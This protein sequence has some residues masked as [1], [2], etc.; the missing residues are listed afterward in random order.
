MSKSPQSSQRNTAEDIGVGV[1]APRVFFTPARLRAYPKILLITYILSALLIIAIWGPDRLPFPRLGTDFVAMYGAGDLANQGRSSEAYD[2]RALVGNYRRILPEVDYVVGWAY[3]PVILP[4]F[5][6]L[7]IFPFSIAHLIWMGATAGLLATALRPLLKSGAEGWAIAAAPAVAYTVVTGQTA[8]LVAAL[9]LIF[10][11]QLDRHPARA[12]LALGA[13]CVKPHLAV[14]L[15]LLA[16]ATGK[17]RALGTA[18]LLTAALVVLSVVLY[19]LDPWLVFIQE[20]PAIVSD[21]VT[22]GHVAW[23]LMA[24]PYTL[25][26]SLGM[27]SAMAVGLQIAFMLAVA[28]A[29]V[30]FLARGAPLPQVAA[31]AVAAAIPATPYNF[32]YDWVLLIYPLLKLARDPQLRRPIKT[33]T[34]LAI[35]LA[36]LSMVF[37]PFGPDFAFGTVL[38]LILVMLH[39][40][41]C[42]RDTKNGA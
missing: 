31:F 26:L 21:I 3:P 42:W 5:Q 23:R 22:G 19:G 14:L 11:Q 34:I 8:F 29:T 28:S 39:G 35:Y 27:T 38:L 6:V 9:V 2:T 33:I 30:I 12:G 13:L 25:A 41:I 15:P 16:I 37:E 4:V 32:T 1:H 17:W 7:A 40:W 20:N 24:S 10:V 36:P 18:C